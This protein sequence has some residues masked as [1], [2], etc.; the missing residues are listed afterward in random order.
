[1]NKKLCAALLLLLPAFAFSQDSVPH[2]QIMPL[3][4]ISERSLKADKL[5]AVDSLLLENCSSL[6]IASTLQRSGIGLV[7]SYGAPGS[8]AS[9]RLGGMSSNYVTVELNGAVVNSPTLG[10]A[11]LS[12]IPSFFIQ[13]AS[14]GERNFSAFQR[15]VGIAATLRL[16]SK[17]ATR[18][19]V[20]LETSASSLRNIFTGISVAKKSDR[21][22]WNIRAF[23][24]KNENNF[25]YRDI[26]QWEAPLVTQ[27][28]NNNTTRGIQTNAVWQGEKQTHYF[29]L[30]YVI[31][32]ALLPTIMGGIGD[33]N[34]NQRDDLFQ[35]SFHSEGKRKDS[36]SGF[37]IQ[38]KQGLSFSLSNQEYNSNVVSS[39]IQ[40]NQVNAFFNGSVQWRRALF[41][42]NPTVSVTS[43]QYKDWNSEVEWKGGS[44][45][46]SYI[47]QLAK[48]KCRMVSWVKPEWR[49]DRKPIVSGEVGI[50][51][52]F[53]M[54]NM[55]SQFSVSGSVKS[56]MPSANDLYW[57]VGGNVELLSERAEWVQVKWDNEWSLKNERA[58]H[59][60]L[61]A[62][63]GDVSNW[64]QWLPMPEDIWVASNF[65]SVSMKQVEEVVTWKSKLFQGELNVSNRTELTSTTAE[66][67]GM[68]GV[69]N[70]VYTPR[71]RFSNSIQYVQDGWSVLLSNSFVS[72]RYTDEGNLDYYALP[73]FNILNAS[74]N[75]D[76]VFNKNKLSLQCEVQ[77]ITN[78]QYQWIRG[79]A[80]PGRVYSIGLKFFIH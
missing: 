20:L 7:N 9:F 10:M 53:K 63:T 71:V 17:A 56:R 69:F 36:F 52:P 75:K 1:M 38:S 76:W 58:L 35:S 28:N 39:Q 40:T 74:L 14:I 22:S 67:I 30:M 43:L 26:H 72:K 44:L 31:R 2:V 45:W 64:I 60:Q 57:A 13:S 29:N 41:Q 55:S 32:Y 25:A 54:K 23:Q 70:M 77:N 34:A 12:L 33:V 42:L 4:I 15:N 65:K 61:N 11:D 21:L 80:V 73:S 24:A 68:P 49:S 6:D 16:D 37:H 19:E 78:T 51:L 3:E 46:A 62:K 8:I 79:Y 27:V 48:G 18:D 59:F 50:E 5:H 66:N 47:Q